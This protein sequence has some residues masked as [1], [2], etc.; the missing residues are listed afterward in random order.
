MS[1]NL[2]YGQNAP[3]NDPNSDAEFKK[4]WGLDRIR[5]EMRN[6]SKEYSVLT[7]GMS[8][9]TLGLQLDSPDDIIDSFGSPFDTES[10]LPFQVNIPKCYTKF[11]QPL[12]A[13]RLSKL[14][15][16][17]LIYIFYNFEDI[18]VKLQATKIL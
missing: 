3:V 5:E 15:D 17:T 9:T 18:E 7:K 13:K 8:L 14:Q 4:K 10:I 16:N 11:N 1:T 2:V 12:D 6:S